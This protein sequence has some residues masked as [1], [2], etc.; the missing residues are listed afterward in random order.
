MLRPRVR[1]VFRVRQLLD[2]ARQIVEPLIDGAQ[3][4]G[5]EI[6]GVGARVRLHGFLFALRVYRRFARVR[7]FQFA[8]AAKN[9]GRTTFEGE[10]SAPHAGGTATR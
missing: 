10:A 2:P 7:L 8:Q 9:H 5:V 6:V 3:L 4:F 1:D